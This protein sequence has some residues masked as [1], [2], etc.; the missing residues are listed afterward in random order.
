[1][2]EFNGKFDS[3]VNKKMTE[4][5]LEKSKA[6]IKKLMPLVLLLG[7]LFV[8]LSFISFK[9]SG[10]DY[11]LFGIGVFLILFILIFPLTLKKTIIKQQEMIERQS[12]LMGNST[13]ESYKFDDDKVFIF[14]TKGD[15]YR[16][17]VETDYDYFSFVVEDD[18]CYMMF[19]SN[20]QCHV[21]FKDN[22]KQGT[23]EEFEALLSKH[24]VG[25]KYIKKP[26]Q[27]GEIKE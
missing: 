17:A 20:V 12:T 15:K 2:I 26:S 3:R 18:E 7:A 27:T 13:E 10:I 14:S 6:S 19:I 9:S 16:S 11:F 4:Y 22:L 23:L 25:D 8:G 5:Q 21:I 1:M 24:F